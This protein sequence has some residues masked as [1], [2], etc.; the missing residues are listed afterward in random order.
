MQQTPFSLGSKFNQFFIESNSILSPS[1]SVDTMVNKEIVEVEKGKKSPNN[2]EFNS[3]R[4][5]DLFL[6]IKNAISTLITFF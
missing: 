6:G 1:V 2:E 3:K 5:G 4:G